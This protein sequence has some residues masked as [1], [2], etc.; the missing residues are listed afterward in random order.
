MKTNPILNILLI[1]FLLLLLVPTNVVKAQ[2]LEPAVGTPLYSSEKDAREGTNSVGTVTEVDAIAGN[3][4]VGPYCDKE[5]NYVR[6]LGREGYP[7]LWYKPVGFLP[8]AVPDPNAQPAQGV[9][10]QPEQGTPAEL[11][12]IEETMGDIAKALNPD[13]FPIGFVVIY[14]PILVAL[15]GFYIKQE[16]RVKPVSETR[17]LTFHSYE[18]GGDTLEIQQAWTVNLQ[19]VMTDI[20]SA[21]RSGNAEEA[22]NAAFARLLE[23]LTPILSGKSKNEIER[24]AR[25]FADQAMRDIRRLE[26]KVYGYRILDF[27]PGEVRLDETTEDLGRS[28]LRADADSRYRERLLGPDESPTPLTTLLRTIAAAIM[29]GST[30]GVGNDEMP[31][32]VRKART[33]DRSE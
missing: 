27:Q 4:M 31:Q 28:A 22:M 12:D 23:C 24:N 29:R 32:D 15:I 17:F 10:S 5:T 19:T 7:K 3:M 8:T 30:R 2:C 21:M 1:G 6:M 14:L 26:P 11:P 33:N 25:L 9:N 16:R 13:R 20:T 18:P